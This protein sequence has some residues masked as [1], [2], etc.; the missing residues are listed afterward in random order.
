MSGKLK[1]SADDLDY[2]VPE[3]SRPS[4][5]TCNPCRDGEHHRCPTAITEHG[6]GSF[7]S[8]FDCPCYAADESMH[9]EAVEESDREFRDRQG[10]ANDEKPYRGGWD[11]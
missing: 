2:G 11:F 10:W 8:S 4:R 7:V 9:A 5:P 1:L 6:A 3:T